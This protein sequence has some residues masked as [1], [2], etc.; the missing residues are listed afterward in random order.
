MSDAAD[1]EHLTA[2]RTLRAAGLRSAVLAITGNPPGC[3]HC[4]APD[5]LAGECPEQ[6]TDQTSLFA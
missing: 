2:L 6:P 5:H 3:A 1:R 4:H